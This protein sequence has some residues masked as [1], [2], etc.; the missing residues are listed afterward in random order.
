MTDRITLVRLDVHK[1]SIVAAVAAGGLRGEV[2]TRR[3]HWNAWCAGSA[4]KG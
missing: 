2:Q 1:E 4:T 3:R